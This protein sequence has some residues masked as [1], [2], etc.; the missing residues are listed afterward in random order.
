MNFWK[1]SHVTFLLNFLLQL[2]VHI[3]PRPGWVFG[4]GIGILFPR[5]TPRGAM[6]QFTQLLFWGHFIID[7]KLFHPSLLA[8]L[9]FFAFLWRTHSLRAAGAA[10]SLSDFTSVVFTFS[11]RHGNSTPH[12]NIWDYDLSHFPLIVSSIFEKEET[13]LK[14]IWTSSH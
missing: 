8:S 7:Q 1:E 14:N 3:A 13:L 5:G 12:L 4:I 11:G 6:A 2:S 9:I 10:S